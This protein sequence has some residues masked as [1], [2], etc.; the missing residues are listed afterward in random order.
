[1][2]HITKHDRN[3][4]FFLH[5]NC[6][7][8]FGFLAKRISTN[9]TIT[10]FSL[11][12]NYVDSERGIPADKTFIV[13]PTRFA[14]SVPFNVRGKSSY[15]SLTFLTIHHGHTCD[16]FIDITSQIKQPT[17]PMFFTLPFYKVSKTQRL[18]LLNSSVF[19]LY[20][21]SFSFHSK[22]VLPMDE[23]VDTVNRII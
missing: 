1:M 4:I 7:I 5:S 20:A 19:P 16:N 22:V 13:V 15:I 17:L 9:F 2:H 18:A 10:F 12:L 6:S 3:S 11:F 21:S 14:Y 23:D 8:I